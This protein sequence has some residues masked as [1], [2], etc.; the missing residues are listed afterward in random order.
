MSVTGNTQLG[1]TKQ[2]LIA[3][4]VQRELKYA[5]VLSSYV[6]DV[7]QFAVKGAKSISFPKL[8]SF[9]V[10]NR[11]SAT[12]G[13]IQTLVSAT[14]KLDLDV[15]AYV[16]W[17]IDASDEIQSSISAKIEFSIRAAASHGRYVDEK[18]LEEIKASFGFVATETALRDKILEVRAWIKRNE[19]ILEQ[20]VYAVSPEMEAELLQVA[21]F[22]QAQ[23]YG[24]AVI[25]QG[26]IGRIYGMPV[27]VHSGLLADE[28]F[29][30]TRDA[31]ALGF[32]AAPNYAAQPAIEYGTNSVREAMDQLFGVKALQIDQGTATLVGKSA[33]IAKV[34]G[35]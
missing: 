18:I 19:G 27:L 26:V 21:E 23:V 32:Q 3:A 13:N 28:S 17:L 2:E 30:W 14:D 20:S 31:V 12:A 15:N 10:Q 11:A 4:A 29:I 7:S 1:P 8:A 6:S 9:T 35:A 33:L 25:P 34:T 16:S 5:A 24:Q 22:S